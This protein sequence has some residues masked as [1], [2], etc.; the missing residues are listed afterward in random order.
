V[1]ILA[2]NRTEPENPVSRFLHFQ[3]PD[4]NKARLKMAGRPGPHVKR[5]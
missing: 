4:L 5:R 2:K 3:R 1:T